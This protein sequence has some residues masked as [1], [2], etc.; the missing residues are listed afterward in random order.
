MGARATRWHRSR[1]AATA[2]R[3]A[4]AAPAV[5]ATI[6][7]LVLPAGVSA[8]TYTVLTCDAA[9][10]SVNNAWREREDRGMLAGASCPTRG[11]A[12]RGLVV[13]N[14][15]N[16]GTVRRGKRASM[17]FRAP[18]GTSLRSIELDWDGRRVNGDWLLGLVR[19]DGRLLAGCRPSRRSS[20]SCRLGNPTG[21]SRIRRSLGNGGS[22]SIEARCAAPRGCGTDVRRR[23]GDRTR[24]RLAVHAA[25]V[26][27]GDGSVP[28]VAAG[29]E[30]LNG[31]WQRAGVEASMVARD[32]VGIRS[33]ALVVD[34]S[35][36]DA[37]SERCDFTRPI[38]CPRGI[39]SVHRLDTRE[40]RDGRHDL[41][42]SA[43]D[44]AGNRRIV[45]RSILVDNHA[46]ARVPDV[47]VVG[48][49]GLRATNS[50]DLRWTPPPGQAAPIARAHY[51]LCRRGAPGECVSGSR[52]P[53]AHGIDDLAVPRRGSWRFRVWLEDKAG[54]SSP[55]S[56]SSP[57]TLRFDDRDRARLRARLAD[58]D[59]AP[60]RS[61]TVGFGVRATVSGSLSGPAARRL[62]R[63][64]LA[65][66][67]RTRGS[68]RFRQVGTTSTD[69]SG[70]YRYR[71]PAG[72]SRSVR[73]RFAGDERH[74]PATSGAAL[75]VRA[76][77][78][79]RV[80]RR[81]VRNGGRVRF[82]GR[83][84][85]GQVPRDGK[86]LQL[87]AFY[88]DRW[89]TFAVVRTSPR[90]RWRYVYRFE[91]TT[92]RVRYPFRVRVPRERQYPYAVGH[93][94][95]VRVTVNGR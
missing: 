35:R 75:A 51:R 77:S 73:V 64:P 1:G 56:A 90:G 57:V 72:P 9:P 33:T 3:R 80:S 54:N 38:P 16:V 46:P 83:L 61:V 6:A 15:V 92:G 36:R 26:V 2:N 21:P 93:S 52:A 58:G 32:N 29:G 41:V 79:I 14:R 67:T 48:G 70:T 12:R 34:G 91:A 84:L 82:R 50:F 28:N 39:R 95:V 37:D 62:G 42:L 76:R 55:S 19:G 65:I 17:A 30:L 49:S 23:P 20:R 86:L 31:G 44:A 4:I 71:L 68:E 53:G 18:A 13:R 60:R 40:L 78:S 59:G 10:G 27:V 87:E 5:A 85:G 63:A 43:V 7:A 25:E 11:D 66:L 45:D 89:R 81:K 69:A 22:V 8:G 88:R 94:R 74:R 24:A 47:R